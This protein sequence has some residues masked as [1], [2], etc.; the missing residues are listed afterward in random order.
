M[1]GNVVGMLMQGYHNVI[2][3]LATREHNVVGTL[4]QRPGMSALIRNI[5]KDYITS[6]VLSI[7]E[8]S[9]NNQFNSYRQLDLT[10]H[11]TAARLS[12]W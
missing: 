11:R 10:K 3:R 8:A 9:L 5:Q 4:V 2:A 12:F 1:R 7:L 6:I